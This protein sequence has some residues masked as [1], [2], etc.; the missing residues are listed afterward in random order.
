MI[1]FKA[2]CLLFLFYSINYIYNRINDK[3]QDIGLDNT[4]ILCIIALTLII[5]FM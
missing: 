1:I 2:I 3:E 5:I 4:Y